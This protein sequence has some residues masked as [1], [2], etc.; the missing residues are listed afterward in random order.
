MTESRSG[1]RKRSE[2][3]ITEKCLDIQKSSKLSCPLLTKDDY[4]IPTLSMHMLA[5]PS[6]IEDLAGLG[7]ASKTCSY[8]ASRVSMILT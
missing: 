7:E 4:A 6:D 1:G 5:E 8:Y 2:A 3:I